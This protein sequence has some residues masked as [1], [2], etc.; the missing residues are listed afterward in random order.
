M[1]CHT[2]YSGDGITYDIHNQAPLYVQRAMYHE[3]GREKRSMSYDAMRTANLGSDSFPTEVS[4]DE[5]TADYREVD[6]TVE[7]VKDF[8]EC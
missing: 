2:T 6:M 3:T 4:G 7:C 5:E 1:R 8:D